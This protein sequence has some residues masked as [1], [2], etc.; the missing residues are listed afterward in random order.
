MLNGTTSLYTNGET[1]NTFTASVALLGQLGHFSRPFLDYTG[2]NLRLTRV[3]ING[4]SPFYFDRV[5]DQRV[6]AFGLTQQIYGP[7]RVGFQTSLNLDTNKSISTDY[8]VEYSRRSYGI[9]LRYNPDLQ[10]GAILFRVSDFNWN[11]TGEP[12]GGSG[13]RFVDFGILQ[14]Y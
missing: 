5:V 2:F 11:N 8:F 13:V 4:E 9:T 6:L 12:F 14:D 1:Q 10:L 7:I 3:F